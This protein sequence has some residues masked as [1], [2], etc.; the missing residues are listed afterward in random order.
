VA[1][2]LVWKCQQFS[3]V[4]SC[5]H[6]TSYD[7]CVWVQSRAM[8]RLPP[9]MRLPRLHVRAIKRKESRGF[10]YVTAAPDKCATTAL[11]RMWSYVL[12]FSL[13]PSPSP[14]LHNLHPEDCCCLRLADGYLLRCPCHRSKVTATTV[15][16]IWHISVIAYQ[17]VPP[18]YTA[19]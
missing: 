14:S 5:N 1:L 11:D 9:S 7:G 6:M 18:N 15:N 16:D 17:V 8:T 12:S 19:L 10:S 2:L 13:P 4:S 3:S